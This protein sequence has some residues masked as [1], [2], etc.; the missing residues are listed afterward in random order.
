MLSKVV[1]L[2]GRQVAGS[3][4]QIFQPNIG[5]HVNAYYDCKVARLPGRRVAGL[6][7][8]YFSEILHCI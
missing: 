7:S 2:P 4:S 1:W 6:P 8:Q 5:L 3:S